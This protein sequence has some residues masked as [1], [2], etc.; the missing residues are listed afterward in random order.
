MVPS[1]TSKA[2]NFL[3]FITDQQRWDHVGY[4]GNPV[5][6]TPNIDRIADGGTWLS[7][8]YVSS[9]TCM[10]NRAT[11]MTGRVP[12]VN[13]V[14]YNGIP[15]N[16]DSVTFVDLLLEAG[17]RTALIGKSHLQGMTSEAAKVPREAFA[18]GLRAP[19]PELA[20]AMR[21]RYS[22]DDYAAEMALERG[23]SE[24]SASID[25]PYYGFEDVAFCLGHGDR[26]TGHYSAWLERKAPSLEVESGPAGAQAVSEVGAAQ[27]YKPAVPEDLYPTR[28]VEDETIAWL[29]RHAHKH[30]GAPFFLQC[31]FPDPHHPFTPP[32]RYYDMYAPDEVEL[33]PSFHSPARDATPPQAR[34][35]EEFERGVDSPRWTYPFVAGEPQARDMLAK[36]Y[37]QIT[38]IDDAVG[39]VLAALE[40]VG[41]A[42]NTVVCFLS[43][44]GEYLGDHG[45][46]L[47]GPMQYQSVVR[48]PFAWCD[49]DP[50]FNR[51]RIDELG[52]TLDI[53]RTVLSRAGLRPYNGVQGVDLCPLFS[54][55]SVERDHVLVEYTTQ[56]PYLGLDDLVTVSTLIDRRWRIS[57]WQN[58]EWGELYDL[59]MDPH[60]LNNLWADPAS[61]AIR[62]SLLV[63]LVHAIQ[64]H[65]D[66]S[67]YPLSVS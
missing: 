66:T 63:R 12:R 44:H 52:S 35:W 27:V 67:P 42:E 26:V 21:S 53:A 17:Y 5:L 3:F 48:T 46:M 54:G 55:G 18:D 29:E 50:R 61:G 32:G 34:L 7:R 49:P 38:M 11:F 16:L 22:K 40:R 56:Y 14:R 33:P 36:T 60:E 10:S 64:N 4:A 31:S 28:F 25:T 58:R 9:P 23:H 1:D 19:P 41:R 30:G 15:L 13:G 20:E 39:A 65:A 45:L 51:G 2:P 8:F 62:E 43:D 37:G 57:V 59:A 47:K 24:R 6:R